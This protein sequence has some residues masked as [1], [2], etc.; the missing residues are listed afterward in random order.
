MHTHALYFQEKFRA[1]AM[2]KYYFRFPNLMI[3]LSMAWGPAAILSAWN[4]TCPLLSPS[5]GR[6]RPD[7]LSANTL[8][9]EPATHRQGSSHPLERTRITYKIIFIFSLLPAPQKNRLKNYYTNVKGKILKALDYV[10]TTFISLKSRLRTRVF[11][12]IKL[13]G[14]SVDLVILEMKGTVSLITKHI[15]MKVTC[16]TCLFWM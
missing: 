6:Q 13:K 1:L 16:A 12:S 8:V 15:Q 5:R 7:Q 2:L 10:I 9:P 14:E 4:E 11:V 3:M